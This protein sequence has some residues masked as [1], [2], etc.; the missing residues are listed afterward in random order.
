MKKEEIEIT[1]EMLNAGI[2][3]V[4]DRR[5]VTEAT[6][7]VNVYKAMRCLEANHFPQEGNISRE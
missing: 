7:A 4:D 3:E 6:I 2:D 1:D 5:D